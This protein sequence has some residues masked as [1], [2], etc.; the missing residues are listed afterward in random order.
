[1]PSLSTTT[2]VVCSLHRTLRSIYS[3]T[4]PETI[5]FAVSKRTGNRFRSRWKRPLY[6]TPS[7]SMNIII[8]VVYLVI[9]TAA[10]KRTRRMV[11][12]VSLWICSLSASTSH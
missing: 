9:V 10:S 8:E 3:P 2:N 6:P 12:G 11:V 4:L 1:M 5:D 7:V